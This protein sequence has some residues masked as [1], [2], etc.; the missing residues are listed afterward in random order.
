MK[1]LRWTF[2]IAD[3]GGHIIVNDAERE[4]DCSE[5]SSDAWQ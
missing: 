4:G 2:L 3:S 1:I 5:A